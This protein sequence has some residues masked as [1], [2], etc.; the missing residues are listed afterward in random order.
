MRLSRGLNP[1]PEAW[2]LELRPAPEP[3]RLAALQVLPE[4]VERLQDAPLAEEH[5]AAPGRVGQAGVE[6]DAERPRVAGR[7]LRVHRLRVD[8][9]RVERE[10]GEDVPADL[11][12]HVPRV[13]HLPE[14]LPPEDE[15]HA[16]TA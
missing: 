8:D 7:R 4:A 16:V 9:A 3:E 14:E 12:L 6:L 10:P 2:S 13:R 15:V 11:R 5:E 1:G